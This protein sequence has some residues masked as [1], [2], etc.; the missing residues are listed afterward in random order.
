M[1]LEVRSALPHAIAEYVATPA[2][3]LEDVL[4][5]LRATTEPESA[6]Q[7]SLKVEAISVLRWPKAQDVLLF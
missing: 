6:D 1:A 3:E 2:Q 7:G 4:D 5:T